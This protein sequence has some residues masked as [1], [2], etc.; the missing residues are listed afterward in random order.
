MALYNKPKNKA[1]LVK[2]GDLLKFLHNI[3]SR[4]TFKIIDVRL[5]L[6]KYSKT[7]SCSNEALIQILEE[8]CEL[9]FNR[10]TRVYR[11]ISRRKLD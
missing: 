6:K 2:R 5:E 10:E 3:T 9:T 8:F 4:D 7:I 1:D 11:V